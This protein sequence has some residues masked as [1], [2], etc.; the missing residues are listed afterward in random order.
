MDKKVWIGACVAVALA[1]ATV[2][3]QTPSSATSQ[4]SSSDRPITV[5]G[6][7]QKGDQSSSS[8]TTGTTGSSS[9]AQFILANAKMS[10]G[11]SG[12]G[13]TAGTTGTAAGGT[14]AGGT[15]AGGAT[16]GSE[17]G[18]MGGRSYILDASPSELQNHVGHQI[19]VTGTIDRSAS[20]SYGNPPSTAGGTTAGGT[21][22][23]G[24]TT[25]AAGSTGARSG[26]NQHLKVTSV[27]MVS[28]TCTSE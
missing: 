16:T 24:T 17:S 19:E 9:S 13:S 21:T 4:Q 20:S 28:S 22:A 15:T 6:C 11:S 18:R 3:A 5:T 8:A 27:K 12:S 26:A 2:A 25:G 1:G 10:S 14:T 23:G 7:L